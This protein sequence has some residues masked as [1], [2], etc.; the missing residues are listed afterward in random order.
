MEDKLRE[1]RTSDKS[2]TNYTSGHL[3]EPLCQAT[4]SDFYLQ[5]IIQM[6]E[7]VQR[8]R[9]IP[10]VIADPGKDSD[11][12][13]IGVK[14][15]LSITNSDLSNRKKVNRDSQIQIRTDSPKFPILVENQHHKKK[16]I[17][18]ELI[19]NEINRTNTDLKIYT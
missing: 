9:I 8:F 2:M 17:S 19:L 13:H 16:P 11:L 18:T 14:S 12:L 5:V 6:Q 10:Q 3:Q 15:Q 7:L 4:N 1:V